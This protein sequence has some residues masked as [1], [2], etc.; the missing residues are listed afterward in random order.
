MQRVT[1][2]NVIGKADRVLARCDCDECN[3]RTSHVSDVNDV[4]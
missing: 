1:H 3:K 4:T 2:Y